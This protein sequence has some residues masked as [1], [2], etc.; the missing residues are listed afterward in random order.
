MDNL[1]SEALP[2]G[3][4]II[5]MS[6]R[7]PG[8]A[9]CEQYWD[10]LIAGRECLTRFTDEDLRS[11]GIDPESR[12]G[13][14][15]RSRGV[16]EHADHFD[17]SL[18]GMSPKEAEMMDPQQRVLLEVAWEALENSGY[19][20]ARPPGP[21]GVFVGS[22]INTYFMSNLRSRPDLVDQY[23]IFPTV[24]LNE[25]D[26][27]ATRIAYRLNLKGP[28]VNVQTACS[29]SLVAVCNA[30]QSLLS[31]ECDVA[32]AGAAHIAFPQCQSPIHIEGGMIS[33]DGHCRPF[34]H[35]ASGT[36]F[37]DGAGT[38]V[39]RRLE[40]AVADGDNVVAVIRGYGINNDGADKA[41]FA[42]P[43][44]NGQA[45]VVRM[46]H[47]FGDIDAATISYVEAHGTGTRL[48][49]P[50]EI[51]GLTQAFGN[52]R[53][54]KQFCGIGSVKANIGHLDVAAGVAGLI[55]T[56]LAV[57]HRKLPPTINFEQPNPGV[58]FSATP[59]YVV[60]STREWKSESGPLR[61]GV[62]SF[63]IG[64]TNAHVVVEE[65]PATV[66]NSSSQSKQRSC[67]LLSLSAQSPKALSE[68]RANLAKHLEDSDASLQD[69]AYTLQ[70]GRHPFSER[71]TLA[72]RDRSHAIESLRESNA[73]HLGSVTG[74]ANKPVFLFPG[75][76]SQRVNM[77][78]ALYQHEPL[79][80]DVV[81]Q[82]AERLMPE[83][84]QDIR[85]VLFPSE[86]Q[87]HEAAELIH[88]TWVTQPALFVT[89]Y[90]LARLFQSW[91]IQP[92]AMI[93]HSVGEYTAA[94]LAD[95]FTLEVALRLIATRG[96]LIQ[97]QRPGSML[98][99]MRS[100]QECRSFLGDTLTIAAVNAPGSCV[101][102]GETE[103][104]ESLA[105]TLQRESISCRQLKT[106]HA[107]HSQMM[108]PVVAPFE[109]VVSQVEL[110]PP[111]IPFVSNVSGQW[112][113]DE[114]AVDPSYWTNHLRHGVL[115]AK[116]M[117]TVLATDGLSLLEIGPGHTL[118][119]L[120]RQHPSCSVDQVIV[121]SMP[122]PRRHS[123][124][125]HRGSEDQAEFQDQLNV[126]SALGE[127]WQA[128]VAIDWNAFYGGKQS[129]RIPL[130]TYP[131][132]R[133]RHWVAPRIE[134]QGES[135]AM[136][137]S[138]VSAPEQD[139]S[140]SSARPKGDE[141]DVASPSD[142]R[143]SVEEDLVELLH[144]LSGRDT[145]TLRVSASFL[146]LGFDS[147]FLTQLTRAIHLR[148]GVQ[149]SFRQVVEDTG[150]VASLAQLIAENST[151][152][153]TVR[154]QSTELARS[155][156]VGV[157]ET[158]QD[159]GRLEQ[160]V[161]ELSQQV[162]RLTESIHAL[163]AGQVSQGNSEGEKEGK[164]DTAEALLPLTDGQREIWLASQ[165]GD[166]ASR[167]FNESYAVKI[168]G[169]LHINHLE[170]AIGQLVGRHD[171]LRTTFHEDGTSQKVSPGVAQEIRVIDAST[172]AL[173]E[174]SEGDAG[175]GSGLVQLMQREV[176]RPF[177]LVK[178]P[179]SRFVVYRLSEE[180]HVLLIVFHHI[181]LDGWSWGTLLDELGVIYKSLEDGRDHPLSDP[182]RYSD[183]VKWTQSPSHMER[184]AKDSKYWVGKFEKE[185]RELQLPADHLRPVEKSYV[186]GHCCSVIDSSLVDRLREA[187]RDHNCTLFSFMLAG[188]TVWLQRITKQED[189][190]VGIPF[191]GQFAIDETCV[192]GGQSLVGHCVSM[193]PL[194]LDCPENASFHE[195]LNAVHADV[196]EAREHQAFTFG[197]LLESVEFKRDPSRVP[198]VSASFNLVRAHSCRMDA[199]DVEVIRTPKAFNYFDLTLDIID[200]GNELVLDCKFNLDL[201]EEQTA[202]DWMSQLRQI[203]EQACS[204]SEGVIAGYSLVDDVERE[205]LLVD[206]NHTKMNYAQSSLI[207]D[208]IVQQAQR[209]PHA[210]AARFGDE[211]LTYAELE[212][213]SNRLA[214]YLQ[215]NVEIQPDALVGV[216]LER[217]FEMLVALLAVMKSGAAYVPLDP[218]YPADRIA[219]ILE[220]AKAVAIVSES[221]IGDALATVT[222]PVICVDQKSHAIATM[223][224]EAPECHATASNL[225][226]VIYTSGSTGKPKGVQIAHC[227]AVNFLESMGSE[228]G[229]DAR[230]V[231][232]AV[233]TISFDIAVLELY[234]PLIKGA[235]VVLVSRDVTIDGRAL[236][237]EIE[238]HGV[239]AMQ[240]TP[241]TWRLMIKS[242]WGGSPKLRV[243]C[244]GEPLAPELARELLPRCKELWNMYGPTETT[245][246]STCSRVVDPD[247]IHI[248]SPIGNTQV[249]IVD[250]NLQPMPVGV[251]G[252]LM[253]GGDGLSRGYRGRPALTDE[254]FI[255]SPFDSAH[256][257]YR[258]GDLAKWRRDGNIDCLGRVDFQV[259]I[260]GFRIELGEIESVLSE[261]D[262]VR[263]SVVVAVRNES[264]EDQLVAYFV[265]EDLEREPP[266]EVL[267][268]E[269]RRKLPDYMVPGRIVA[270]QAIP[271]T[272]NGK[273]D[274]NALPTPE[275]APIEPE[276]GVGQTPRTDVERFLTSTWQDC[277]H[278]QVNDIHAS[279]FDLGGH[280][281]LAVTVFNE[282][283][284]EYGIRLPL[285]VLIRSP[286]IAGL[287]EVIEEKRGGH[288]TDDRSLIAMN[289]VDD[290]KPSIFFVHG[291][292]GDVL[293]YRQLVQH[294]GDGYSVYGLQS[295]GLVGDGEPDAT[296]EE[297]AR[298]Y[299]A[300]IQRLLPTGP[301]RLAGYCLGGTVAFEMA[302]IL[303]E[304]GAD[305]GLVALLD[306]Y[307]FQRMRKPGFLSIF[308]QRLIFHI[309]NL[310]R[311][312]PRNW[313]A[314]FG[315]KLRV[316]KSGELR[317]M[318]RA[319]IP[320]FFRRRK[321]EKSESEIPLLDRNQAAAF[322]Y[323][324]S[325][326]PGVLTI[327]RPKANY[328]FFPGEKMG[329]DE[330]AAEFDVIELDAMPH[331]MLEEPV[332]KQL[333]DQI[334]SRIRGG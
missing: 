300:E 328:T 169:A 319:S 157:N 266:V 225:A 285:G 13:K 17:A 245:V 309:R 26:F 176:S 310:F 11:A 75:Q 181:I 200:R 290:T 57:K 221:V 293:L 15:C 325:A 24:L 156:T 196:M 121:T 317:L 51:A 327:I 227:S 149:V 242:G 63:G 143:S 182:A 199:L 30:C 219:Y 274:R 240:A 20:H 251:P 229:L 16:I 212:E 230:D 125:G 126:L 147:L 146:Q 170:Q 48:G 39:L 180:R 129:R 40:D 66:A 331:A 139:A 52:N 80:R 111:T 45:E 37:S 23:G 301:Y 116:G 87:T 211:S 234:L 299:V 218:S 216:C 271:T 115:F 14:A 141:C 18:F 202:V 210:V 253:I 207:H 19:D 228:P 322:A 256:K 86:Q 159:S 248:G 272:P 223:P 9:N 249:Y 72:C 22:G 247:D 214:H 189:V 283:E 191:A 288:V 118:S 314:Y 295:R 303:R 208:L 201:Y 255:A 289:S 194:R 315:S 165:L 287:A 35:N 334:T 53:T 62:S 313:P 150:D 120:A 264:D 244:G 267:R 276:S 114:E 73:G 292:G 148:F 3:I 188:F 131:F 237:Q 311:V 160:R 130:P 306:T 316:M 203:L 88:Q 110:N 7:F 164:R 99:I 153:T 50:I 96:R 58:D 33:Q 286:T 152:Q 269:L 302:K 137:G 275:T 190:V 140:A 92:H 83:L 6:G 98:A 177:D 206:L 90:A 298:H 77:G 89:E 112:I 124:S 220:D 136:A 213:R 61:A 93:G 21:V 43:S 108:E 184:A 318:L 197:N 278:I 107:F 100:E 179:L 243:L 204:S 265:P 279:F 254:K 162:E 38:V 226:Y 1:A 166:D 192:P 68:M 144:E 174:I 209:T 67:A 329:W 2:E 44:V 95:V 28:A 262:A 217:S 291:A 246:W 74:R 187:S 32:L 232:L 252:E 84:K 119:A 41:G 296:I 330:L 236:Q 241:A 195:V 305:I 282:I 8:S 294:L 235:C 259:K 332:V 268:A 163:A 76:G 122:M 323:Q 270:L 31:Y 173:G 222:V 161:A 142:F 27:L 101:V 172:Q 308:S 238:R 60:D 284:K 155:T 81:D 127:L 78:R 145:A 280:S 65:P 54:G 224:K 71:L 205:R 215:E 233:T 79:Y 312:S 281:L 47:A 69:V 94:C 56:A 4:A 128:D 135:Q 34:D 113:K 91:G 258:T 151:V 10:N 103:H 231:L 46:A 321:T 105:E 42:A 29:T 175:L 117:E 326:Y 261:I 320:T 198:F 277:L 133:S 257:I 183:Y 59:F 168:D 55:K 185:C 260:R 123:G 154:P 167:T 102:S 64:G 263:Q 138:A 186:A 178:G 36:I 273:V 104:I 25:K 250:K 85:H 109:E 82:C 132:Q 307:N 297:M 158:Q 49:D 193:L 12:I 5:G 134:K 97:Q 70:T 239:S 333:S 106:S 304:E 324:P 171:A